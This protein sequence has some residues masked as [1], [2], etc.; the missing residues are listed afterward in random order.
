MTQQSPR[1]LGC[2]KRPDFILE[3]KVAAAELLTTPDDYVRLEEGTYNKANNRFWCTTCYAK[4]GGPPGKAML[5]VEPHPFGTLIFRIT[6]QNLLDDGTLIDISNFAEEMGIGEH[7]AITS[8]AWADVIEVPEAMANTGGE[9]GR[10]H[11]MLASF[12]KNI[13]LHPGESEMLFDVEVQNSPDAKPERVTLKAMAGGGDEG[14]PV[15][16]ILLPR[17]D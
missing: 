11:D 12:L 9:R 4:A 14:E 10:A 16:T 15:L 13:R 2:G 17:E 8:T 1:C 5:H 3:Y 6:R 7:V